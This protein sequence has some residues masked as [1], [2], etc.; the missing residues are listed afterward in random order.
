MFGKIKRGD[1]V[2][3]DANVVVNKDVPSG[4]TVAGV[5][6][7][8]ISEKGSINMVIYGEEVNVPFIE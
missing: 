3:I 2:V 1:N 4:V 5:P 7:K 8:V 6:A